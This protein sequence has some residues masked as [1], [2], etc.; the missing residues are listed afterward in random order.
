MNNRPYIVCHMIESLDGRIDCG[1]T[2][3]IE[4]GNEYYTAL[5]TLNCDSILSGKVTSVM[6]Y[7]TGKF[8][9]KGSPIDHPAWHKATEGVGF[10]IIADTQG[11]LC[12]DQAMNGDKNMLILTSERVT[13][14]YLDYL[15]TKG[16]SYLAIG[17]EHIDLKK[18]MEMLAEHF[19]VKRLAICGGG[20]I[21]GSFLRERLLDEISLQV[22]PGIDGRSGMAA[23]FDGGAMDVEPSQLAL[24]SVEQMGDTVWMRYTI[25]A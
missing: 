2:E 13:T 11:T 21:N 16:I 19:D 25:K 14:D 3:K 18:A 6:H 1:M 23:S 17:H 22:A 7:A 12:Y 8:V 10:D 15:R 24:T 20:H 5:D 9:S 4:C